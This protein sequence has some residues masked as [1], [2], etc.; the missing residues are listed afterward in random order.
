[1]FRNTRLTPFRLLD[2]RLMIIWKQSQ[3]SPQVCYRAL[4]AIQKKQH[5]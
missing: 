4:A 3:G 1:M 5:E 2:Y